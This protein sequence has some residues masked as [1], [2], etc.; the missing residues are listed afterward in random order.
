MRKSLKIFAIFLV[1]FSLNAL[2]SCKVTE[3]V[4]EKEI[5]YVTELKPPAL[6]VEPFFGSN[7]EESNLFRDIDKYV[8]S[9]HK[10]I[11]KCLFFEA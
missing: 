7:E 9:L 2:S 11:Q 10:A 5:E 3:Y 6:I 8:E 1:N 4:T